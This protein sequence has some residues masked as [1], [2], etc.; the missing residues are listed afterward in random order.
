MVLLEHNNT[1]RM[2]DDMIDYLASPLNAKIMM[3]DFTYVQKYI[4]PITIIHC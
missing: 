1:I 4:I 3:R 2:G